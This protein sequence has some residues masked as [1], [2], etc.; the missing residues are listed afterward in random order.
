MTLLEFARG[1]GLQWALGIFVFGVLWRLVGSFLLARRREL[2]TPK[3]TQTVK[4]GARAIIMRSIPPHELEKKIT[5]QHVT[6]YAWHIGFFITL[7]LFGPH[8]PFFKQFL[9]FGWP[10]LPNGIVMGVAAFTLAILI[11]LLVRRFIHPVLR[12]ISTPDDYISITLVILPLVTGLL[13]YSHVQW[14]GARY[15]TLLGLHLLSVEALLVWFPFSKLMH[16]FYTFPSRYQ[17]GAAMER[18][19]VEA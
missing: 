5:F 9:G 15:E 11:A 18:K 6:G 2:F 19:G 7:L 12:R 1:P 3:G 17:I 14:L 4:A 10:A 8:V 16:L 13:A